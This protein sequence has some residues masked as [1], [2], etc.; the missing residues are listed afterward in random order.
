MKINLKMKNNNNTP[1]E[2]IREENEENNS[3]IVWYDLFV[4]FVYAK[5]P[6]IYNDACEYADEQINMFK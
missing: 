3:K 5:N 4:D 6:R 2:N 1:D